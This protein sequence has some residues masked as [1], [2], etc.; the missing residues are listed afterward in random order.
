VRL[1]F[2]ATRYSADPNDPYL[3]DELA[4]A[5]IARGHCVDVLV[6][7]WDAPSSARSG[8][9]RGRSGERIVKVTPHALRGMG[10]VMF[11]ASKLL[12]S[13]HY[14]ASAMRRHF[15]QV[16]HDAVIAWTPALSVAAP[17]RQCVRRGVRKRL[18]IIFDFFPM[19][20]REAGIIRSAFVYVVA[21]WLED[22]LYRTFTAFMANLPGNADY[23]RRHYPVPET[24]SVAWSPIWGSTNMVTASHWKE[25]RVR[26][27]LPVD[28]P[29]AVFGGQ[30]SE[31]RGIEQI[32]EA[33]RISERIGVPTLYLF[34]GDGRLRTML[35]EAAREC[36]SIRL[37]PPV[38]RDDYLKVVAVCDV[39][40]VATVKQFTSW[41]FPSKTIDYLR[42]GI[43][44]V[45]AVEP[46]SD[47]PELLRP[48]GLSANV[49]S[50]D[51]PAMQAAV[52]A[53]VKSTS[54]ERSRIRERAQRCLDEQFDVRHAV[55]AVLRALGEP[56]ERMNEERKITE[57]ID[58]V[59]AFAA[60]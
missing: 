14:A 30:L 12:L 25:T 47:Y 41:A 39:G 53:V 54:K 44:I 42:A 7:D 11:Q 9:V 34:I 22:R 56:V 16:R 2:L 21:K 31:G 33:A 27:A 45:T 46:G 43:P 6:T 36:S 55:N 15:G 48:Y 28:R 17:L 57:A 18:L 26:L 50:G 59:T 49:A 13:S 10:R 23:L 40:L 29:I 58:A 5:L 20:H 37:A 8:E 3:T 24:A 32:I 1:L 51:A 52:E 35:E 38:S 60:T 4:E 19:C